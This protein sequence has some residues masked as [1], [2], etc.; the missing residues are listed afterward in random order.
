MLALR[1]RAWEIFASLP[2]PTTQ[3]E[4]WRRTDIRRFKLESFGVSL[5]GNG[6]GSVD[7]PSHLGAQLTEDAAGGILVEVDGVVKAYELS[8][9]LR[10]QGVIFTDMHSAVRE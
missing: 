10:A 5:N 6:G 1:L 7:V 9:E 4:A 8:D 3:D 2:V